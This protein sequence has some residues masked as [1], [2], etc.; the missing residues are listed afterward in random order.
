MR[1]S[2]LSPLSH[3]HVRPLF[4][5]SLSSDAM[6]PCYAMSPNQWNTPPKPTLVSTVRDLAPT[7][8]HPHKCFLDTFDIICCLP[9]SGP[10]NHTPSVRGGQRAHLSVS[11]SSETSYQAVSFSTANKLSPGGHRDSHSAREC[12]SLLQIAS[13]SS[14]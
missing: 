9:A 11:C 7:P 1:M 8:S 6:S 5:L 13:D 12:C 2:P 4:C 3:P 10:L 14:G